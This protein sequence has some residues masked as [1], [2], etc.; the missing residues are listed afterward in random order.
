MSTMD[1]DL[2][3]KTC[4]WCWGWIQLVKPHIHPI[5][6]SSEHLRFMINWL[7]TMSG[8]NFTLFYLVV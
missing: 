6:D 2:D 4:T 5:V 1:V 3:I 8:L 7:V